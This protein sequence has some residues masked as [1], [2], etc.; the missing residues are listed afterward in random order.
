MK[1]NV[2]EIKKT[3]FSYS[4][5]GAYY[6][7]KQLVQCR[8]EN[9]L[10]R[11]FHF[12]KE[13]IDNNAHER[14]ITHRLAV[15]LGIEFYKWDVDVEYNRN[16]GDTKKISSA[17][18]NLLSKISKKDLISGH[19]SI[20]PDIIVHKRNTNKNLLIIEF[21]KNHSSAEADEY[22][23]EKIKAYLLE[24]TLN[25]KFAAFIKLNQNDMKPKYT[26]EIL[27]QEELQRDFEKLKF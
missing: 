13:L 12:D 19:K 1:Q 17:T 9:A 15:H 25:Y 6:I 27:T 18:S 3:Q 22:D 7:M 26:L 21:K 11:L 2:A 10:K 5:G 8:I 20:Y 16:L 14:S 23:K 24:G 4:R